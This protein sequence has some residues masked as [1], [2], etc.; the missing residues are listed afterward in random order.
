MDREAALEFACKLGEDNYAQLAIASQGR[1]P[2]HL[3]QIYGGKLTILSGKHRDKRKGFV[4]NA[5]VIH[6]K[7]ISTLN[8][9]IPTEFL[10]LFI[11]SAEEVSCQSTRL[12][13]LHFESC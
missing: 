5:S 13:S 4:L 6:V 2:S 3:M 11:H 12:N 1:E 10:G 9:K 8:I 7:K